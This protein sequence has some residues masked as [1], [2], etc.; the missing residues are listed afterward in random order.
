VLLEKE[1]ELA[2]GELDGFVFP[3][4]SR[5]VRVAVNAAPEVTSSA[6]VEIELIAKEYEDEETRI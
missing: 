6:E 3:N 1:I 5:S 4:A 2:S